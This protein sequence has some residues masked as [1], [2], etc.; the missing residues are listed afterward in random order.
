MT[1]LV[2]ASIRRYLATID[3]DDFRPALISEA[4]RL[5]QILDSDR[6]ADRLR[7]RAVPVELIGLLGILARAKII[8]TATTPIV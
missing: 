6:T 3:S 7:Y 5:A 2:V 8:K 4:L 1:G